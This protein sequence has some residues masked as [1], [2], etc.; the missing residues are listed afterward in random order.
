[1]QALYTVAF[2][3][4]ENLFDTYDDP[5]TY[6]DDFTPEGTR[7]WTRDRYENKIGKLAKAISEIGRKETKHAPAI[8]GLAEVENE[9]VL[10]DLL[11][12]SHLSTT[13]YRFIHFDSLDERGVDIAMLYNTEVF[14][15][16]YAE[17]IRPPRFIDQQ[18]KEDFTR[19]VLYVCGKLAGVKIHFFVVH[20]P[21]QREGVNKEKRETIA[22]K[23]KEKIDKI[24]AREQN[25]L[26]AI[27][28]D[29]NANPDA[30]TL[31]KYFKTTINYFHQSDLQFFNP[32][33]ILVSDNKF[34]TL[35]KEKWLLYDQILFS[36]NFMNLYDA[37]LVVDCNVFNPKFLQEWNQRYKG[38]PYRTYVGRKYLGGY[39]DHFPIYSILKIKH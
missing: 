37:P 1:M 15:V 14:A 12:V 11:S 6:D 36:K 5:N 20:L 19:D 26:V 21:S 23:I 25:P 16:E 31:K 13:P 17:A 9:M 29:F 28:G 39:S 8:V 38:Q 33:E 35:H 22:Q 30:E 18:G 2:Y 3:N 24:I 10:R 32:M 27:L 34:T 7:H 4:V